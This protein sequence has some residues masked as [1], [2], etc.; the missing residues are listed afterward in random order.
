MTA[1]ADLSEALHL[2]ARMRR[3]AERINA[4][5]AADHA[6][7]SAWATEQLGDLP[8]RIRLAEQAIREM[9][10][11]AVAN[12]KTKTISTPWGSVSTR[13]TTQWTYDD[14]AAVAWAKTAAPE[15]VVTP[16]PV[17]PPARLDKQALKASALIDTDGTVR[18]LGE[19]VPGVTAHTV[20][21]ASI[22]IDTPEPIAQETEAA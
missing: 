7:I 11:E 19:V 3:E 10:V 21:T 20:V 16:S 2:L 17:Q 13:T 1:D 15:L 22:R 4:L 5:A 18:L 6:R 8:D 14:E 12:R 9:A